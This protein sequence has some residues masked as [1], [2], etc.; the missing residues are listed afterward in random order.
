VNPLLT[1][2]IGFRP[3]YGL[4]QRV[5]IDRERGLAG[6]ILVAGVVAKRLYETYV[7]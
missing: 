1:A 5:S 4:R 7:E 2:K 3:L 6:T